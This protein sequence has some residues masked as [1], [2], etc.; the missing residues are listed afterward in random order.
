MQL[1]GNAA[2]S[3]KK[4]LALCR[5][6]LDQGWTHGAQVGASLPRR[7]R[8]R[9]AGS[10]LD[11]ASAADAHER[12]SG[13]GDRGAA[14]VADDRRADRRVPDDAALDGVG[15][16]DQDRARQALAAGAARAAEPLRAPPS[17]SSGGSSAAPATA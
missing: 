3:V 6:V 4:R 9:A 10:I 7:G 11:A 15:D 12:G 14:Q 17:K 2:L 1:H 13:A 5:R 8:G 16:P